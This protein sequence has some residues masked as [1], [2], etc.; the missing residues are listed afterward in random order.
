VIT[1]EAMD[2]MCSQNVAHIF[3]AVFRMG[4]LLISK[5]SEKLNHIVNH[6]LSKSFQ[7]QQKSLICT[8]K[9]A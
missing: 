7:K 2:C 8:L 3:K 5:E 1:T 9:Y 6:Q 4:L